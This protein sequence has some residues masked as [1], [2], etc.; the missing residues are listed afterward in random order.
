MLEKLNRRIKE[1]VNLIGVSESGGIGKAIKETV[2][3]YNRIPYESLKNVSPIDVYERRWEEILA[4]R[5]A[6][7]QWTLEQR[8]RANLMLTITSN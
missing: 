6:K 5:A 4:N 1:E 2:E 3:Q 8:R 7:K